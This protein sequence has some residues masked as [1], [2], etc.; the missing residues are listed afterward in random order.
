M[1]GRV[2]RGLG[3]LG[4]VVLG[5]CAGET[6]D[7]TSGQLD[8]RTFVSELVEGWTLVPGT[9]IRLSFGTGEFSA[10]AGCNSMGVEYALNDGVLSVLG[11]SSTGMGCDS[12]RHAQDDW[13]RELLLA[14]PKLRLIEPRLEVTTNDARMVLL[15]RELQ[16]PDRPLVGTLWTGNGFGDGESVGYAPM[17]TQPTVRFDPSGNVEVFTPCQTGVG[18]YTVAGSTVSFDGFAYDEA[19]C[20]DPKDQHV[21][22]ETLLVLDGSP[23]SFAIEERSLSLRKGDFTLYFLSAD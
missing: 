21:S 14:S 1:F 3:V 13:L 8:G 9:E 23:V 7:G 22:N 18:A 20:A 16:S 2:I 15:D 17:A 11:F 5:G 19:P 6:T 12:A 4:A 10:T